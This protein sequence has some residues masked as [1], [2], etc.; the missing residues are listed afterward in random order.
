[1]TLCI[2]VPKKKGQD[3]I[4]LLR[5]MKIIDTSYQ[6]LRKG[7]FLCIPILRN[8]SSEELDTCIGKD[9]KIFEASFPKASKRPR[10]LRDALAPSLP[11]EAL[12]RLPKSLDIIGDI[13]IL[14]L[15][16]SLWEFRNS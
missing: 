14:R 16:E 1:M 5:R 11:K 10:C 4:T 7:E 13:A 2:Q 15:P 9:W 8:P 6:I 3:A 12:S